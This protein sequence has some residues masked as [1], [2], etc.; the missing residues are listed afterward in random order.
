LLLVVL[1]DLGMQPE[2]LE[3][4]QENDPRILELQME[5]QNTRDFLQ[6]SNEQLESTNEALI[7]TNEELQS[8]NEEMQSTNEELETSQEELRSVNEELMTVNTELQTKMEELNRT[9]NDLSNLMASTD[10]A[11]VFLDEQLKI[12][13][14]TPA[15]TQLLHLVE[16]D[17]GRPLQHTVTD[18]E[19]DNLIKDVERLLDT[20]IPQEKEIQTR[21]GRWYLMRLRAYRTLDHVIAGVVLTFIDI[22]AQ[23]QGEEL[24]RLTMA[25]EQSP[26]SVI[27]T[28]HDGCIVYVNPRF[29]EITG[30]SAQEALG[31]SPNILKSSEHP[32]EFYDKLWKT[33]SSD[34]VWR[35]EFRNR[36]KNGELYWEAAVISPVKDTGG[37]ITHYVGVQEDVTNRK[38]L[39]ADAMANALRYRSL[40]DNMSSGVAVYQA[41]NQG[42]DFVFLD[43]NKAGERIEGVKREELIGRSILEAFPGVVD[44][45]LFE[46][47]QRVWRSGEP[48]T[49]PVSLYRDDKISGWRENYIYKL[50]SGEVVAVYNDVTEKVKYEQALIASERRLQSILDSSGEGIFALDL[51]GVCTLANPTCVRLLGYEDAGELIGQVMHDLIHHSKADGS[52]Y[53][54][55]ECKACQVFE[56]AQIT[57]TENEVYWRRDGSRI[58]VRYISHPLIHEGRVQGTV[59]VF[60][61]ISERKQAEREMRHLFR[62]CRMILDHTADG[63][64]LTDTAG[65]I[66]DVNDAYCRMIGFS[67]AELLAMNQHELES[68]R[69]ADGQRQRLEREGHAQYTTRQRRKDGSTLD[70][71]VSANRKELDGETFIFAFLRKIPQ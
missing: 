68:D 48:A 53:Y 5:L 18:F 12:R 58:S 2:E 63:L 45:G 11:I 41:R 37:R 19:Y 43:F 29:S 71:S 38:L 23:K 66:L 7:S 21:A 39:E 15:A 6:S 40:V 46:I 70:L 47:L 30:Y 8:S 60:T 49:H 51:Q 67:R 24:K 65:Q 28:D 56:T 4:G 9:N 42:E 55:E 10:L 59:V 25:V 20:L 69:A 31:Q 52:P 14:F 36:R 54:I 61:D 44:F 1:E 62:R 17:I 33:L 16:T 50:P 26:S 13:R 34:H 64:W 22:H 32:A 35:G 3:P 27:M 57:Q